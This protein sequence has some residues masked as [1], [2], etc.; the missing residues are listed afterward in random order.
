M[1]PP[2]RRA[3]KLGRHV[4]STSRYQQKGREQQH[5]SIRSH[6]HS[7]VAHRNPFETYTRL[8]TPERLVP[9]ITHPQAI[10]AASRLS[11]LQGSPPETST[12]FLELFI[13]AGGTISV[14]ASIESTTSASAHGHRVGLA[15]HKIYIPHLPPPWRSR[16]APGMPTRTLTTSTKGVS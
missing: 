11:L 14:Q 8:P 13:D 3:F 9:T 5:R 10:P 16:M 2:S 1:A 12:T 4:P 15:S 6:A 7:S